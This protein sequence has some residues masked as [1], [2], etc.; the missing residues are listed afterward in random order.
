MSRI[1]LSHSSADLRSAVAL[2]QWLSEQE[3]QL[4]NE[5]FLDTDP[6]AG[7]RP[8]VRWKRELFSANSRCEA[9]IC[10]LSPS[11]EASHECKTEYRT[12]EGLGKQILCARLE[13][14]GDTDITSEWQRCDLFGGDAATTV[15][16][17]GGPPVVFN[18]AGLAQLR[19]GIR[20]AG[21]GPENF[22]WPPRR[23][24]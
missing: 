23:D 10:L 14:T 3:P 1:F 15:A 24:P 7:L 21:V 22:V 6:V 19:D 4:V 20:G 9:V 18:T 17:A 13:E 2:K 8:G 11:W 5:I 16:V 12:A